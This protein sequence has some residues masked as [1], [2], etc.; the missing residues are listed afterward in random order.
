M[1][2]PGPD[3]IKNPSLTQLSMEFFK[4]MNVKM[5]TTVGILTFMNRENSIIS[6]SEPE[7]KA[8]FLDVFILMSI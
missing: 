1:R 8:D 4:L 7:K 2:I 6:L 3:V 5:P